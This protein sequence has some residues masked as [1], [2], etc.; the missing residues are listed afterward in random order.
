M[1]PART[2]VYDIVAILPARAGEEANSSSSPSVFS[3]SEPSFRLSTDVR[4]RH[5]PSL[6]FLA[7]LHYTLAR[8]FTVIR[9][10]NYPLGK[11][12]SRRREATSLL[13]PVASV[14]FPVIF[15]YRATSSPLPSE[16]RRTRG[17]VGESRDASNLS[18]RVLPHFSYFFD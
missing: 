10:R 6:I 14:C 5:V 13:S 7:V 17:G 4:H 8:K 3:A 1:S 12:S 18:Y 2:R 11:F 15:V 9:A 16:R